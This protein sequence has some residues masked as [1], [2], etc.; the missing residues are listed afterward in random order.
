MNPWGWSEIIHGRMP[1]AEPDRSHG[2]CRA[3]LSAV[4][5][6]GVVS[7]CTLIGAGV[8]AGIDSAIP[9]PYEYHAATERVP[10][11]YGDRIRIRLRRGIS[12]E[13]RYVGFRTPSPA[14]IEGLVVVKT[15]DDIVSLRPS[16]IAQ[17][18]VE[19]TGRGWL[20]G[21]LVGLAVDA[22]LVIATMIAMSNIE[23]SGMQMN[24]N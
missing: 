2:V 4:L 16:E 19:V 20:Y 1:M 12:F 10:L 8:G 17:M 23:Y 5:F 21:G 13:A 7:G 3:S 22:T 14:E 18:G 24:L 9:G 11:K 15:S 6:A